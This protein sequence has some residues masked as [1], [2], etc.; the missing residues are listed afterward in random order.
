V[1]TGYLLL[2]FLLNLVLHQY[3]TLVKLQHATM[4]TR[5]LVAIGLA[6]AGIAASIIW[7]KYE[8]ELSLRR[9]ERRARLPW[10]RCNSETPLHQRVVAHRGGVPENTVEAIATVVGRKMFAVELDLTVTKGMI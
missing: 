4:T 9:Q 3:P 1:Q 7:S 2:L 8:A 10:L 6:G 5:G